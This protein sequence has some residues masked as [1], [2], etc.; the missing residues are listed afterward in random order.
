MA[1]HT[2]PNQRGLLAWLSS[3]NVVLRVM[4]GGV[5]VRVMS[6][7][8]GEYRAGRRAT[9][10]E[11][12]ETGRRFCM[13]RG[14]SHRDVAA[15]TGCRRR[16]GGVWCCWFRPGGPDRG[17][18]RCDRDLSRPGLAGHAPPHPPPAAITRRHVRPDLPGHSDGAG[19]QRAGW[20]GPYRRRVA[21]LL[22]PTTG[23]CHPAGTT[24]DVIEVSGATTPYLSPGGNS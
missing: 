3:T 16:D 19:R 1:A 21:V 7:A 10:S 13:S 8:G 2:G 4:T 24:V 22:H 20:T 6:E 11:D 5:H 23:T 17:V 18:G 12:G 14:T 15:R 9:M